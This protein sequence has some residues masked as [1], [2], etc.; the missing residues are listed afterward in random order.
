MMNAWKS[1]EKC[2]MRVDSR[3]PQTAIAISSFDFSVDN[4]SSLYHL[5]WRTLMTWLCCPLRAKPEY[6]NRPFPPPATF[7]EI[8]LKFSAILMQHLDFSEVSVIAMQNLFVPLHF[9]M[10][11][12]STL[13]L[14]T[15]LMSSPRAY[16][17]INLRAYRK[18]FT[19][20]IICKSLACT[21]I[22]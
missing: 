2:R 15:F 9:F 5:F 6:E 13:Q 12:T 16:F 1:D 22:I 8:L 4:L 7:R 18:I 10:V 14:V 11:Q 20:V 21:C 19:F 17:Q 3:V